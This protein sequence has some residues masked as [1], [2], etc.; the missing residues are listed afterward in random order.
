MATVN[1]SQY[2]ASTDCRPERSVRTDVAAGCIAGRDFILRTND[3]GTTRL[4]P[5]SEAAYWAIDLHFHDLRHEGGS[6][7]IEG[8]WPVHHVQHMLGHASLQQTST[9]LDA[10]LHG[11]HASMQ[12]FDQSRPAC[13]PL[14]KKAA[15]GHRPFRKQASARSEKSFI[16]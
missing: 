2:A 4:S 14:A 9:Y 12:Q 8:G 6:R 13:K 5:A 10:T 15:R 16:H 3:K 11:L 1:A 7:L